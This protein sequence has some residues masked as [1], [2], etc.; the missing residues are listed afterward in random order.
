MTSYLPFAF[1]R[2]QVKAVGTARPAVF[3][4]SGHTINLKEPDLFNRT[5]SD[6]LAAVEVER[7]GKGAG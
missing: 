1:N 7:W 5:A 6:L 3:S 4:Q 2:L